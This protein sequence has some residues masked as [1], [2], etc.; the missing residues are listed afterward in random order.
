LVLDGDGL[1]FRYLSATFSRRWVDVRRIDA[2]QFETTKIV[3]LVA[4]RGGRDL[5]LGGAWPISA[6]E[7]VSIIEEFRARVDQGGMGDL[8]KP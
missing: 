4:K 6:D 7:L 2:V 3:K 5:S 8:P 1:A